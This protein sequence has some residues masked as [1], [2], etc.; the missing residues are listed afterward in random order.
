LERLVQRSYLF[1]FTGDNLLEDCCELH[2]GHL[3]DSELVQDYKRMTKRLPTATPKPRQQQPKKPRALLYSRRISEQQA[4][5]TDSDDKW[6]LIACSSVAEHSVVCVSVV[7]G[8]VVSLAVQQRISP[9]PP[10][11]PTPES[12]EIASSNGSEAGGS[13]DGIANLDDLDG[14]DIVPT[15]A[16]PPLKPL[17]PMSAAKCAMG[18]IAVDSLTTIDESPSVLLVCGGYDRGECLKTCEVFVPGNNT[19]VTQKPMKE[20][21]GRVGAAVVDGVVFAVGG[22]NGTTE[23]AS[24]EKWVP[25]EPAWHRVTPMPLARSHAGICSVEGKIY[26]VGGWT[27]QSG[28]KQCHSYDP[29]SDTWVQLPPLSV[30]RYQCGTSPLPDGRIMVLGGGD[31]WSCLSSVEALDL[32]SPTWYYLPEL[33]SVRRGAGAAFFDNHL[34]A[35]G[36]SDS[37]HSL[38]VCDI[39]D[40]RANRWD[41][42]PSLSTC[43]AN[44]GVVALNGRLFAIGGFSGKAFLPTMESVVPGGEWSPFVDVTMLTS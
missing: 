34:W 2:N 29:N 16:R 19:W 12:S 25:G 13:V 10:S 18:S 37:H 1:Y 43:R 21:R 17:A 30:G 8:K 41:S 27:E 14:E 32:R 3:S 23:L 40:P 28:T 33:P 44:A 39:Y 7:G 20:A 6:K 4:G 15:T 5:D 31:S 42:G 38:C 11:L 26:C 35:V 9:S 36:G 24:V 22:S